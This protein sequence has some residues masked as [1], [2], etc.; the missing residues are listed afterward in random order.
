MTRQAARLDGWAK[1]LAPSPALR[2]AYRRGGMAW[3]DF[4]ERYRAELAAPAIAAALADL[5]DRAKGEPVTL[6]YAKADPAQNSA[7]VLA[8]VLRRKT[9]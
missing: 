1:E 8:Q 6:L 3:P 7:S 9:G 4:V 2:A 5:R